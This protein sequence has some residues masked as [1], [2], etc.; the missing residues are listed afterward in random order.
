MA[1][2]PGGHVILIHTLIVSIILR[3]D[4]Q[5]VLGTPLDLDIRKPLLLL[6]LTV[7][8]AVVSI[9]VVAVAFIMPSGRARLVWYG[10]CLCTPP[11]S[12]TVSFPIVN[13]KS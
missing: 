8:V 1:C 13:D 11:S 7:T 3:G 9:E 4:V 10:P 5:T 2:R 12:L 6:D